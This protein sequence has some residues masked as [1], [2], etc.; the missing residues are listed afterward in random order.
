[1]FFAILLIAFGAA[2]VL[3]ALGIVSGGFWGLFWGIVFIG[4]FVIGWFGNS[5]YQD[6]KITPQTSQIQEVNNITQCSNMSLENTSYC[7]R[8]YVKTFYNYTIRDVR[9]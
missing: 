3:S 2:L 8:D 4:I 7:L 5:I 9:L 1:M 6:Y